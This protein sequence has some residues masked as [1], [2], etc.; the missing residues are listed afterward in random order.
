MLKGVIP[1]DFKLDNIGISEKGPV[2]NDYSNMYF[3]HMPDGLDGEFLRRES[4]S[5]MAMISSINEIDDISHF[6]TGF[7]MQGGVLADIVWRN[8][9]D[10]GFTLLSYKEITDKS[11]RY[12]AAEELDSQ[13][14]ITRIVKWND[15]PLDSINLG[16]YPEPSFYSFSDVRNNTSSFL[17]FYLDRLY[18]IKS[19]AVYYEKSP[20]LFPIV[21]MNLGT[22]AFRNNDKYLAFGM[23]SKAIS[24][25]KTN[26]KIN[27]MCT[28]V[29]NKLKHT[30][31]MS[32][33]LKELILE[34]MELEFCEFMWLL[35]D[36]DTFEE[37]LL[38]K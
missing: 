6:R 2:L 10:H 17:K 14:N 34:N 22:S 35:N 4:A 37:Q 27:E 9:S 8:L 19:Y 33:D 20:E 24:M 21:L 1:I 29:L 3:F 30:K 23:L 18:Y 13:I 16:E 11:L 36:I 28:K 12:D 7:I 15:I 26:P 5:L 25:S 32:S 31:R 38:Q